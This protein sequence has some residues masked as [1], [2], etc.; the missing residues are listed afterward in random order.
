MTKA[1]RPMGQRWPVIGPR[2]RPPLLNR[3]A[4]GAATGPCRL[5]AA[6]FFFTE[7]VAPAKATHVRLIVIT[8]MPG[9]GKSVAVAVAR[10]MQ[11]PVF[12]MGDR[13]REAVA[14]RGLALAPSDVGR[15]ANEERALHGA[16]IW[17]RRTLE[18]IPP[19]TATAVIDGARS[20]AEVRAFQTLGAGADVVVVAVHSA[21]RTRAARLRE[22]AR[23]DD[24]LTPEGF[25]TRDRRELGWGIGEA[26]ALADLTIVN[27]GGLPR[28]RSD[29]RRT[30]TALARG[31][32][33]VSQARRGRAARARRPSA[34]RARGTASRTRSSAR[35][36]GRRRP[37]PG[38]RRAPRR[39]RP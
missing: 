29:L 27:E 14:A 9:A 25:E 18:V 11:L 10:A 4:R 15:I 30:L 19:G 8:G 35:S 36:R 31:R 37:S 21:P 5:R 13:V 26:I 17:A 33:V 22:R 39:S 38:R 1:S 24:Q 20:A 6:P 7:A 28:F 3:L 32:P 34:R 12:S 16:D 23:S 2:A